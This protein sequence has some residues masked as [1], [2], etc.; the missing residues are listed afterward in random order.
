MENLK[1]LLPL[2]VNSMGSIQDS[3]GNTLFLPV[4]HKGTRE[5]INI[6]EDIVKV[7]NDNATLF[8]TLQAE[9]VELRA[10]IKSLEMNLAF[11]EEPKPG[12]SAEAPIK[13]QADTKKYTL[14]ESLELGIK[15]SKGSNEVK[16]EDKLEANSERHQ[17]YH[18]NLINHIGNYP[19]QYCEQGKLPEIDNGT[20][21]KEVLVID[22]D[23]NL[24]TGIFDYELGWR[25]L[26]IRRDTMHM[27][28]I[29]NVKAWAYINLPGNERE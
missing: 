12:V 5:K 6:A 20:V 4:G 1:N 9:K 14:K 15:T 3:E 29:F 11:Y 21:S 17:K 23:N 18:N 16:N 27:G 2:K 25:P 22:N 8:E 28:I 13:P 19:W 10:I 26:S 7:V 24:G